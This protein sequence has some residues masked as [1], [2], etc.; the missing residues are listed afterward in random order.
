VVQMAFKSGDRV[1]MQLLEVMLM[2]N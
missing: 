1:Q 2:R